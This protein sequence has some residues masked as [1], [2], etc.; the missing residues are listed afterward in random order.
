[1][2]QTFPCLTQREV[3]RL[4]GGKPYKQNE[5]LAP[6]PGHD[7]RDLSLHVTLDPTAPDGFRCNSYSPNDDWAHC[8]DYVRDKL[9]L[10][11]WRPSAPL[12]RRPVRPA[13]EQA[14]G[15]ESR[16]ASA[17][18]IWRG[19]VDPRDTIADAYLKSRGLELGGDLT[20]AL[21]F[22]GSLYFGSRTTVG[23]VALMSDVL[24]NEPCG[25]HRIFLDNA[26]RKLDRRMLGRAKGAAI[27]L[28]AHDDITLGLHIGEGVE[29]C[30]AAR[31]LGYRPVWALGSA[32]AIAAFPVL[33]GIEAITVFAENDNASNR[34]AEAC[35]AR[36][37][38]AGLE[39]W[40]CEPRR[41]DM[42]DIIMRAAA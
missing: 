21:R 1:M 20:H 17:L 10:P 2:H 23:I 24:T 28:D 18:A 8:R 11:R 30:L 6:G 26:A 19:A 9:R 25:V 33:P 29:T 5:V 16:V 3:A 37:E 13:V 27:K 15:Q 39:A 41:G 35:C 36:Y 40:I 38:D 32:G 31:Q 34:A 22:H 14:T 42:N 4:L 7:P 12:R